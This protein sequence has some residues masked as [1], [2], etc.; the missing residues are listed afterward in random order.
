MFFFDLGLSFAQQLFEIALKEWKCC[1]N[2]SRWLL[3]GW[4]DGKSWNTGI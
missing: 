1:D 3:L 2:L 4:G